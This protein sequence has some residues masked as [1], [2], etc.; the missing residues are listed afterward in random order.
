MLTDKHLETKI[1]GLFVAGDASGLSGNIVGAAVTGM[2]A[3]R[4][5]AKKTSSRKN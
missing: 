2:L 1:K 4:W 5:M 3:G